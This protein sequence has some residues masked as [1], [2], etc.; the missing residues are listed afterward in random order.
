MILTDSPSNWANSVK[1]V[2]SQ[3]QT[4]PFSQALGAPVTPSIEYLS[5]KWP[6][7]TA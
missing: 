1:S 3:M 5:K 4:L 7:D 6:E 2:K